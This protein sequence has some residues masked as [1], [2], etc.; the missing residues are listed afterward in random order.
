MM[1]KGSLLKILPQIGFP[2][3]YIFVSHVSHPQNSPSKGVNN[4]IQ[5]V[6]K[7]GQALEFRQTMPFWSFDHLQTLVQLQG[8]VT[9]FRG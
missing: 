8:R 1:S 4:L 2:W 9:A 7:D 5:R 3:L 6:A